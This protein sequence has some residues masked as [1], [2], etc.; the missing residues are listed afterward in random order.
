MER[1][2][3]LIRTYSVCLCKHQAGRVLEVQ[4]AQVVQ[5]AHR[6]LFQGVPAAPEDRV[7]R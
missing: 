1:T 3:S 2:Y 4:V 7:A 5:A 6:S